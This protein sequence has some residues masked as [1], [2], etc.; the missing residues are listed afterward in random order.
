MFYGKL[1][2]VVD[3]ADSSQFV[4]V[5]TIKYLTLESGTN[6]LITYCHL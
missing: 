2:T 6:D 1:K 5:H 4:L 3:N